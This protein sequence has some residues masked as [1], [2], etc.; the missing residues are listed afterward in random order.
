MGFENLFAVIG[1]MTG[2]QKEAY[3]NTIP[4]YQWLLLEKVEV[5]QVCYTL[6]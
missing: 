4:S 2:I 5:N 6:V 3:S 1:R